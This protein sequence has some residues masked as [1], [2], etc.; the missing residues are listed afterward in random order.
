[1]TLLFT[2]YDKFWMAHHLIFDDTK[3]NYVCIVILP[4][5]SRVKTELHLWMSCCWSRSSFQHQGPTRDV[6]RHSSMRTGGTIPFCS[7]FHSSWR[8][9]SPRTCPTSWIYQICQTQDDD[10]KSA[11]LNSILTQCMVSNRSGNNLHTYQCESDL[12]RE[13]RKRAADE[14]ESSWSDMTFIYQSYTCHIW[15]LIKTCIRRDCVMPPA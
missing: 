6:T 13:A 1:M 4:W 8:S 12:Y 9:G 3:H 7:S 2:V 11:V 5:L 14:E 15:M 10:L